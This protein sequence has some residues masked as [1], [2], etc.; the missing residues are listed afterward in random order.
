MNFRKDINGLRAFAVLPVVIFHFNQQWLPGGFAG[1]DVFFVISG[2]LMT[3]MIAGRYD[4]GK[5]S[6]W[7]FYLDRGRRIIPA[8]AFLSA[9]LLVYGFMYLPPIDLMQLSKH[10]V[11]SLLFISN[12]IYWNEAGYFDAVSHT[13]W[14]LHTWSLSVEWQFYMIYPIII[15]GLIKIGG[16]SNLKVLMALLG[17]ISF[18]FS[19]FA[20][21]S[22][23]SSTF[24]LIHSRAWE[25][26]AGGLV[27]LYPLNISNHKQKIFYF[28]GFLL[29]ALGYLFFNERLVWPGSMAGIVVIGACLVIIAND[30]EAKFTK[31]KVIQFIGTISY[32]VYLWHWPVAVYVARLNLP[33]NLPLVSGILVSF[34]LGWLSYLIIENKF[35]KIHNVSC[36]GRLL[37]N[38]ILVLIFGL[39]FLVACVF[40][41]KD[42]LPLRYEGEINALTKINDVY[43]FFGI[44]AVWRSNVCHSTPI[45]MSPEERISKCAEDG[46]HKIFLWGD[47]YTAALYPG[48]LDLQ[49]EDNHSFS[50]EQFTDGNGAPFFRNASLADNNKDMLTVNQEKLEI[51]SKIKPERVVITWM[52]YGANSIHTIPEAIVGIKDTI[53]RIKKASPDT[54]LIIVGPVPQWNGTLVSVMLK[55][56]SEH[57][58]YPPLYMDY[59]LIKNMFVWDEQL[60]LALDSYGVKYI[61]ALDVLCNAQGCLTRVGDKPSDLVTADWGHLSPAGSSYLIKRISSRLFE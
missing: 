4:L 10:V 14:L 27:C 1:V 20:P 30:Q 31:N 46:P 36:V 38:I 32:S 61:S 33:G 51:L 15:L 2:Y 29:I 40:Y 49:K 45:G 18:L 37:N 50:I 41:K 56:W 26:I 5:L 17:F 11:A 23:Q 25:M 43:S 16:R 54:K 19:A 47:S 42:G 58:S 21:E 24:Y 48:L 34:F 6:L 8:L 3:R 28:S 13:K 57:H 12:I 60:K 52:M 44:P 59:E 9:A 39:V 53:D 35:R 55:Y 22:Q 7:G